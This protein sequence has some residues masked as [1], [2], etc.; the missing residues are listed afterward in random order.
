MPD[1]PKYITAV[2]AEGE[3]RNYSVEDIIA[4]QLNRFQGWT[5]NA[6]IQTLYIDYDGSVW[7]ANCAGSRNNPN[8]LKPNV[9]KA[10][11]YVGSISKDEYHWPQGPVTCPYQACGC[12][13]DVCLSKKS[14]EVVLPAND[15]KLIKHST[16][17]T[18]LV[19]MG[20]SYPWPKHILWDL[21][22]WCNYSC[23]YCW[24][25]VHNKS[26]PH[27]T[28]EIMRR[29]VDRVHAHWA[30]GRMIRWSFG[31]GEPTINPDFLPLVEYIKN[32]GDYILVVSNGSRS[33][34]YYTKLAR[35]V[36]CL[37]FSLHFEFWKPEVFE[38][39]VRQVLTVFKERRQGWLDIKVMCKPGIVA[40][41][42]RQRD[43]F[44]KI[45][46][47]HA[48]GGRWLG[49]A[50]CVPIRD[51]KDGSEL[52]KYSPEEQELLSGL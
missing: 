14:T 21:G 50:V 36:D 30:G 29:A 20:M 27:K 9:T 1:T 19:A 38:D 17:T 49:Y 33:E 11:G 35:V 24:E 28:L 7:V 44:N 12:G 5:C 41:G 15:V 43:Y 26:D 31:G 16:S 32:R 42:L 22:R 18:E 13:A 51:I 6:G 23:S 25:W 40:E 47:E 3:W 37:Q 10:W 39:N 45:L 2:T 48:A 34:N 52:A 8:F 46:D 4:K